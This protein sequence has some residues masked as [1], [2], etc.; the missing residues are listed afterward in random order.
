M[1]V[2]AWSPRM[3]VWS[4]D[5]LRRLGRLLR[6]PAQSLPQFFLGVPLRLKIMGMAVGLIMIF[7]G[8][9]IVRVHNNLTATMA[10][11]LQNQSQLL[12]VELSAHARESVLIDDLYGLTNLL[13]NAVH[14]RPALRYAFIVDDAGHVLCHS[15]TGGFPG[16][17]L[18]LTGKDNPWGSSPRKLLTNEGAVWDAFAPFGPG[19]AGGLRVGLAE[20]PSRR[21]N[22]EFLQSLLANTMAVFGL[23]IICS[24]ILTWLIMRPIKKLV[25]ATQS[26][27]RGDFNI[28]VVDAAK[29]EVGQLIDAFN[30]M[31]RQLKKAQAERDEKESIRKE[32]LQRIIAT[33]EGERKRIARELH[34]QSGQ[35]LASFMLELKVLERAEDREQF[36]TGITRL[37]SA[38]TD[39]MDALHD[40]AVELRPSVL[41]DMGLL[42][43]LDRYLGDF[44]NKFK[45]NAT[46]VNLGF[47]GQRPDVAVETC[48]YRI[49]QEALTN[50]VKHAMALEVKVILEWRGDRLR[51]VVEDDG[52][53]FDACC[54]HAAGLGLYGME[55]RSLLLGGSFSMQ[56]APGE[57]TMVIF[58]VPAVRKKAQ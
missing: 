36:L 33:Q 14:N 26:I 43:A 42:A 57:G 16:D 9:T 27:R 45:I 46:M 28:Q 41:D 15:F 22:G 50:A 18:R 2:T 19:I 32:F 56:S 48:V 31:A 44:R 47:E 6:A 49:I 30:S 52:I 54:S 25:A 4:V 37:R 55:E 10:I 17:L 29:D 11:Q 58:E 39:E 53:G 5:G 13:K 24:G 40:L 7:A 23:A 38:I 1:K 12:A 8:F 35:A 34:D 21:E 20:A 3:L 51:G